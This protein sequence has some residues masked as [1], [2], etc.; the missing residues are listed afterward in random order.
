LQRSGARQLLL[1]LRNNPGGVFTSAV[2]T[3]DRFLESGKIIVTTRGRAP[4]AS[5]QY[6]SSSGK[7]Y[8]H[9]PLI[10]MI[11]EGSASDS[12]IL[13]GA[14]QDWDRALLVG[15]PT[16]GKGSVQT[17]Y[18]FQDGSGLLLTTAIYYTP[19][20]RSLHHEAPEAAAKEFKTP[21]GRTI[22]GQGGLK[23]DI[24][25]EVEPEVMTESLKKV[26]TAAESPLPAFIENQ[27]SG[28]NT[29]DMAAFCR[30]HQIADATIQAFYDH[31]RQAGFTF[32]NRDRQ[33]NLLP[34][35]YILKR[36][37]AGRI[38]G[39]PGRALVTV[40]ADKQVHKTT[41]YFNQARTLAH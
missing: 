19:L 9:W 11:D 38:W 14:L 17:E 25:L 16:F 34:L 21:M 18:S 3:A 8:P 40:L 2:Q 41:S 27:I 12:E 6:L 22:F 33:A 7:K 24:M 23:P 39:E 5:S 4:E 26:L 15:R 10:L 36:E 30:H 37:I 29:S 31:A 35:R 20:G 28:F 13:A 32:S 1:D